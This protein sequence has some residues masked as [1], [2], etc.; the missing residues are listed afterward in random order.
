MSAGRAAAKCS[1]TP[2]R[3]V[4]RP[5]SRHLPFPSARP[6]FADSEEYHQFSTADGRRIA[7]EL[8]E[9]LVIKTPLKRKPE[10]ELNEC[11]TNEHSCA[12][13]YSES[14]TSLLHAPKP[15]KAGRRCARSKSGKCNKPGVQTPMPYFGS[16]SSNSLTLSGTCRFDCSLGV[17]TKK[18]I[19]LLKHAQDGVLDLNKAAETL[20]VQKRRIY[21]ITNVLEGI[22]LIEK[23]LKNCICWKGFDKNLSPGEAGDGVSLLQ[24]EVENLISNE[25][26]LDERISDMRERLRVLSENESNKKW[27]YVTE[28]DIKTIPCFQNETLIAIKAPHGTTLEVPDPDEAFEYPRSRYRIV[29]R[30]SM[31]PIDVYLVSQFEKFEEMTGVEVPPSLSPNSGSWLG[32]NIVN[33][34]VVEENRAKD[35]ELQESDASCTNT[36]ISPEFGGLTKI[37]PSDL[38]ADADY[39]L[40]TDS[41]VA[42]S[43]M[44]STH[45]DHASVLKSMSQDDDHCNDALLDPDDFLMDATPPAQNSSIVDPP[46]HSD[47]AG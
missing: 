25:H 4:F 40:L 10:H 27:L 37:V 19:S 2:S 23:K 46:S 26:E 24:V 42:M 31:G 38:D 41:C 6:P 15:S 34:D 30:S 13:V 14:V 32:G 44:W 9:G 28:D 33:A 16:P 39:W 45:E 3:D 29:L 36:N 20:D 22:G 43:D 35:I 12:P 1:G 7:D 18:F 21:D 5:L 11:E 17:L 8:H 47:T